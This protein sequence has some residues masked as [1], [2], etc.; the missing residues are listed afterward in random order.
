MLTPEAPPDCVSLKHEP[1]SD[2]SKKAPGKSL[3]RSTVAFDGGTLAVSGEWKC[4][5]RV[6]A[7]IIGELRG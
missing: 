4:S 3:E 6:K 5:T 2:E 7:P 1:A